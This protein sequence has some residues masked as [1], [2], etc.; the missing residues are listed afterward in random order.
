LGN[1]GNFRKKEIGR[2][3]IIDNFN[4]YNLGSGLALL[5]R[6]WRQFVTTTL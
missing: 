6:C 5:D 2:G 3:E 1:A 4:N